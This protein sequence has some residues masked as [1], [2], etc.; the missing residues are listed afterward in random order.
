MKNNLTIKR[1]DLIFLKSE[2][3]RKLKGKHFKL[4]DYDNHYEE[5]IYERLMYYSIS[6]VLLTNPYNKVYFLY[7]CNVYI[8]LMYTTSS[9]DTYCISLS[10][11]YSSTFCFRYYNGKYRD[12]ANIKTL[13]CL[14]NPEKWKETIYNCTA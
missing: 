11:L 8:L 13:V 1:L 2:P 4:C 9:F 7:I 12:S 5:T 3:W 6:N 14:K 10:I